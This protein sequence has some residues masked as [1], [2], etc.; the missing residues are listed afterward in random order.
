MFALLLT[1]V[2]LSAPGNLEGKVVRI[3]DG[4]TITVLVDRNLRV[5]KTPTSPRSQRVVL[6]RYTTGSSRSPGKTYCR[7]VEQ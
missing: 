2:L 7:P 1:C 3:A 4:D 6:C 5:S